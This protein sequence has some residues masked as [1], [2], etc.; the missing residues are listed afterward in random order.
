MLKFD[1]TILLTEEILVH[2][3][4]SIIFAEF[5]VKMFSNSIPYLFHNNRYTMGISQFT[6]ETKMPADVVI[7]TLNKD[8]VVGNPVGCA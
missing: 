4:N 3:K 2:A 6:V 8:H 5:S 7:W 1:H